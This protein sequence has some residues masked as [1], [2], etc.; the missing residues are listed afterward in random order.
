MNNKGISEDYVFLWGTGEAYREFLYV[1]DLAEACI[2]LMEHYNYKEIGEFI[3]IGTGTDVKLKTLAEIIKEIVG[4]SGGMK[5][6]TSK[7]DGMERKLLDVSRIKAL[8]WEAKTNLES[9]LRNIYKWYIS[10]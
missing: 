8:G 3:N 10:G 5:Y 2:L 1:D 4:F 9:G 6:D 7:P